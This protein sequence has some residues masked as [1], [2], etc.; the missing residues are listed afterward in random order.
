M[1]HGDFRPLRGPRARGHKPKSQSPRRTSHRI[2]P[3]APPREG[4]ARTPGLRFKGFAT[5]ADH[6]DPTIKWHCRG[7]HHGGPTPKPPTPM[8]DFCWVSR[9]PPTHVSRVFSR[10]PDLPRTPPAP[11]SPIA[12]TPTRPLVGF[13]NRWQTLRVVVIAE[14]V[15]V[16]VGVGLLFGAIIAECEH[17]GAVPPFASTSRPFKTTWKLP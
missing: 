6:R 9:P 8:V 3:A 12:L 13:R 17:C 10:N 5:A 14:C 7:A 4:C 11:H 2:T 16:S 1:N 15:A